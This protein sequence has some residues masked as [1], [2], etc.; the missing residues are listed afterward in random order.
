METLSIL[1]DKWNDLWLNYQISILLGI[2]LLTTAVFLGSAARAIWLLWRRRRKRKVLT[3][4]DWF[5]FAASQVND[6]IAEMGNPAMSLDDPNTRVFTTKQVRAMFGDM[7]Y[8]MCKEAVRRGFMTENEADKFQE[9]AA[10]RLGDNDLFPAKKEAPPPAPQIVKARVKA[11]IK[12][13]RRLAPKIPDET[14]VPIDTPMKD[15]L[16]ILKRKQA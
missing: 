5:A 13:L 16:S 15:P 9:Y 14:T 6:A 10:F 4:Y 3:I 12:Q 1:Y 8:K 11:S 2:L 7:V